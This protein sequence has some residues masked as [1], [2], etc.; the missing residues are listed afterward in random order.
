MEVDDPIAGELQARIDAE[1]S[2]SGSN[3]KTRRR[4]T[5]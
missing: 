3:T 1:D 4:V 5:C 2:H